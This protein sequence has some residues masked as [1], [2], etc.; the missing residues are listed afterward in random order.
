MKIF[1]KDR[2]L[3]SSRPLISTLFWESGDNIEATQG[4][5]HNTVRKSY[6][7]TL[8]RTILHEEDCTTNCINYPTERF[9]TY[10]DCDDAFISKSAQGDLS[11]QEVKLIL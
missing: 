2:S 11:S 3:N 10:K 4:E 5:Q 9:M 8:S 1:L 6:G 7:I